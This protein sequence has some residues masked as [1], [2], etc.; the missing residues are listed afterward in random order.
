MSRNG[1][2]LKNNNI[3]TVY[4]FEIIRDILWTESEEYIVTNK[5][6]ALKDME[7][8]V[9]IKTTTRFNKLKRLK[10]GFPTRKVNDRK[11]WEVICKDGTKYLYSSIHC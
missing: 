4:D 1:I 7:N 11:V 5:E 6:T 10:D 8:I 3:V 2:K 9:S